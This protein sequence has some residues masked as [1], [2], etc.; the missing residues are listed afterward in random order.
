MKNIKRLAVA[1]LS[2]MFLL[3]SAS[4]LEVKVEN[5][6]S[7]KVV[8]AFSYLDMKVNEWVVDG[9]Y[10]VEAEQTAQIN[11]PS[12]ND[13][14]Y[15]YAEFSNGKKLEGGKGSISIRV[16][17]ESF[18]YKQGKAPKHFTKKVNF[19]RARGNDGKAL[20]RIK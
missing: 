10:N 20:V 15:L 2:S 5:L 9:W 19:V 8:L 3:N 12:N 7:A 1:A 16:N 17:N 14:Y 4:A 11:L 6:T 18:L 13:I